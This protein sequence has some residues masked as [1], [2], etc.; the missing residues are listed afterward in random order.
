MVLEVNMTMVEDEVINPL[1]NIL[2]LTYGREEYMKV[3]EEVERVVN[4][5]VRHR[6]IYPR[7]G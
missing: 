6:L 4:A 7:S 1:A 2:Y 5:L 3:S